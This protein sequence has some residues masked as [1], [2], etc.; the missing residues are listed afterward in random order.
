M[1]INLR[2]HVFDVPKGFRSAADYGRSLGLRWSGF[3]SHPIAEQVWFLDCDP[4]TVPDPLPQG[5][6][7]IG[8]APAALER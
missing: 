4:E 5:I 2:C 1:S 6:E 3:Q 8:P 7:Y